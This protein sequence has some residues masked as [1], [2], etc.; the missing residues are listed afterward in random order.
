[1]YAVISLRNCAFFLILNCTTLPS[2]KGVNSRALLES[3][4]H[5]H[6]FIVHQ[7]F[8]PQ[9]GLSVA[10]TYNFT[11]LIS[12][13]VSTLVALSN[14]YLSNDPD[15]DMLRDVWLLLSVR[16]G[17]PSLFTQSISQNFET[18]VLL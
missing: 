9:L 7:C 10:S 3:L 6:G 11:V 5:H 16:H 2:C 4:A 18:T 14:T 12:P 15:I 13:H 8:S 1:V 17:V